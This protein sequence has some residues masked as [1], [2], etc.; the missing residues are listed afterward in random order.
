MWPII[1]TILKKPKRI[2]MNTMS[3]GGFNLDGTF[4]YGK[5]VVFMTASEHMRYHM[6]GSKNPMCG[7][8][9]FGVDNPFYGKK[10]SS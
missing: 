3:Y 2:T 10:H 5:Y 1:E 9:K 7:V 6:T 4:E 8:R